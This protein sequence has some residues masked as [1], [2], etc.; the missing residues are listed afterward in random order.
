MIL[1]PLTL[2]LKVNKFISYIYQLT[3]WFPQGVQ[4]YPTECQNN[5]MVPNSDI[6]E[7]LIISTV[8]HWTTFKADE[9]S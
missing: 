5:V 9:I 6:V 7:A 3:A 8:K 4:P 2:K 1:L